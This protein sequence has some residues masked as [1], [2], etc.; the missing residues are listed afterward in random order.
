MVALHLVVGSRCVLRA[1]P[2]FERVSLAR[3]RAG[4]L[5]GVARV[6]L[7]GGLARLAVQRSAA[8]VELERCLLD[9]C[10]RDGRRLVGG[11]VGGIACMVLLL[12]E[13]VC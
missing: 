2:E 10:R 3:R 11:R 13:V 4:E 6:R 12:E 9:G 5:D 8:Q 7:D 1:L